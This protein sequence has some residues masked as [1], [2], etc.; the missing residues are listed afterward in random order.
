MTISITNG[1]RLFAEYNNILGKSNAF[2]DV[3]EFAG[4]VYFA[5]RSA[6]LHF[7]TSNSKIIILSKRDNTWNIEKEFK[8]ENRD[9][10]NPKFY[11]D[12]KC[13]KIVFAVT[14]TLTT[15]GKKS[16][17]YG[18]AKRNDN[19]WDG[20]QAIYLPG[21]LSPYRIRHI[22][23]TPVM[24]SFIDY[25]NISDLRTLPQVRF[26]QP[27]KNNQWSDYLP[28]KGMCLCGT[29]TDFIEL[30]DKYYFVARMD[31]SIDKHAGT[32]IVCIDKKTNK[33][34]E[35]TTRIRL[36]APYLFAHEG[37]LYLLARRNLFFKG[38]YDLLPKWIPN[39]MRTMINGLI[40]WFT[41][42][43]LALWE[44][45]MSNL[46]VQHLLNFPVQGDTG[47]AV[48]QKISNSSY[49]VYTYSSVWGKYL[50]WLF[51]QFGET[52]IVQFTLQIVNVYKSL[53]AL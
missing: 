10:R 37:K 50:P 4:R 39:T 24:S 27:G 17:I 33:M 41:P 21:P 43:S 16:V 42:K 5:F 44:I 15:M 29:E 1:T 40:Y 23:S 11:I 8:V 48:I 47:Y 49:N 12:Q 25:L 18:A 26:L 31:Y 46:T 35:K 34:T 32:K 51:G 38:R 3:I 19:T 7:P 14:P 53:Q 9:V 13:L 20:A 45:N 36:D 30:D 6:S 52:E 28:F 2:P 22:E